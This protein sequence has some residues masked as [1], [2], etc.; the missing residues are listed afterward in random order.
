VKRPTSITLASVSKHYVAPWGR[1]AAIDNVSFEVEPGTSLAITGPSG[2]G[3]STLLGLIAGL[4]R[5]S[6]G[7]VLVGGEE[8]SK[9]SKSRR[10]YLRRSEFGLVF[11]RDNLLP[12]LTSIENIA[13]QLGLQGNDESSQRCLDILVE[14]GLSEKAD[15]LPDQLSGGE[16][17]RIAI[18]RALVSQPSVIL[19]DEPT[20]SL[21]AENSALVIELLIDIQKR[22]HTTLVVVTHDGEVA[23][24]MDRTLSLRDG[25]LDA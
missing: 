1:V 18:A 16:R 15:S 7:R 24:R 25:H 3:K 11:Q 9:L 4:E 5:P 6:A 20:G 12:F 17:Q 14:L 23:V 21:D 19:A 22:A 13:L 2:C 10:T 8:L